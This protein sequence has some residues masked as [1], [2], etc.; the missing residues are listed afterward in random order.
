[1]R[2]WC[3]IL[4]IWGFGLGCREEK[5]DDK[6]LINQL[7]TDLRVFAQYEASLIK[8]SQEAKSTNPSYIPYGDLANRLKNTFVHFS[9]T[10]FAI[11]DTVELKN[12]IASF[13][14]QYNSI[15]DSAI[16]SKER[17][18]S[19]FLRE[20]IPLLKIS[21]LHTTSI[22]SFSK[23]VNYYLI[24]EQA[25]CRHLKI[26]DLIVSS[27]GR[28]TICN[29]GWEDGVGKLITIQEKGDKTLIRCLAL[30]DDRFN[31]TGK[32][33]LVPSKLNP[34]KI[35]VSTKMIK[36]T[37]L[38]SAEKLPPGQYSVSAE[39]KLEDPTGNYQWYT[40]DFPFTIE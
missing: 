35:A 36:N 8:E 7:K 30:L 10:S 27:R 32:I 34:V 18:H 39:Y 16:N 1:M 20:D 11:V 5:S 23:E 26:L 9:D 25:Y 28:Y 15:I 29:W 14:S 24:L 13:I 17:K 37:I 33:I 22:Y 38:L 21:T 12:K 40:F 19:L 6:E 4:V 2:F 3:Y 31:L